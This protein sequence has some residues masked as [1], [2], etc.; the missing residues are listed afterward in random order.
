MSIND[1]SESSFAGVTAQ[2]QVFGQIGMA[3]SDY[4]SG[5]ARNGFLYRPTKN[6]DM[7]DKKTS[8]FRD[9]P[10]E[11]NITAIM[12]KVKEA[13]ATRQQNTNDMDRQ[14][15]DKQDRDNLVKREVLEKATDEFIQCLIYRQLWESDWR[16][17]TAG[18][19]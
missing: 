19:F 13:P 2:L 1:L 9:F 15:N 6:K 3:K 16:S 17:K 5:M 10:E 12:C 7:S 11:L 4:I 8:L 14:S 18:E